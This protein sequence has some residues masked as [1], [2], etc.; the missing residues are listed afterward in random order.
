MSI[1]D[2]QKTATQEFT[3]QYSPWRHG[4][5]Y[6]NNV[7]YPSGACGCVSNNY[8]DKKWRIACDD[9]RNE[10]GGQGDYTFKSRDAAARAEFELVNAMAEKDKMEV[11][12]LTNACGE[13]TGHGTLNLSKA[14]YSK[15]AFE[16]GPGYV[17]PYI[18][19]IN[20]KKYVMGNLEVA[21]KDDFW[22]EDSDFEPEESVRTYCEAACDDIRTRIANNAILLPL[23]EGDPGRFV[24]SLAIPLSALPD[25]DATKNAFQQIFGKF[26]DLPD[27]G[28][29]I[30]ERAASMNEA[31]ALAGL[32]ESW[33]LAEG[34]KVKTY[35]GKVM[36]ITTHHVVQSLGKI[37]AIHEKANLDRIP[38]NNEM[39]NIVYDGKGQGKIEP[40]QKDQDKSQSR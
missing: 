38:E 3:P 15:V 11:I 14:D 35:G 37:A 6:V 16:D 18:V 20:R 33:H 27:L 36:G 29:E 25:A 39:V 17:L 9:R 5:W 22:G 13:D 26:V 40:R 28:D 23:D 4:G 12:Y 34:N 31:K 10:L 7:M 1:N 2:F 21:Y 32:K 24:I 19:E 30:A 8:P